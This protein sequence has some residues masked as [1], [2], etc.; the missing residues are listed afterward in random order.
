MRTGKMLVEDRDTAFLFLDPTGI[1]EASSGL[2]VEIDV[3]DDVADWEDEDTAVWLT[4]WKADK[5]GSKFR[6]VKRE[7]V[8]D[9]DEALIDF[10]NDACPVPT[11]VVIADAAEWQERKEEFGF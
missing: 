11:P 4:D 2:D 6:V 1:E 8:W 7:A 10:E 9:G 3:A 5:A